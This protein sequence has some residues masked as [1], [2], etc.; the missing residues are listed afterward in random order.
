MANPLV[1]QHRR[2]AFILLPAKV[3]NPGGQYRTDM[4]VLPRIRAVRE[5]VGRVIE[6]QILAIPAAHEVLHIKG[7][8]H[9]DD[10]GDLIRMAEAEVRGLI[11]AEA[12]TGGDHSRRLV[13]LV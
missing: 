2:K 8:A 7:S 4:V 5:I 12:A 13:L 10:T 6:V 9:G 3:P 11:A 1:P